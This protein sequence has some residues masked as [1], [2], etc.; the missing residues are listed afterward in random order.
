MLGLGPIGEGYSLIASKDHR[1]S[2]LDLPRT[3]IEPAEEFTT[4]VR[5]RLAQHYGE[6]VIAEHGRIPPCVNGAL[7]HEPHCLHAHRL[8]FPGLATLDLEDAGHGSLRVKHYDSFRE[9]R[10]KFADPGQYLYVERADGTC[11]VASVFGFVPRQFLRSAAAQALG[12]PQLA[13]WRSYPNPNV[14]RAAQLLL[15]P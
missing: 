8:V 2:M 7:Q 11:Q 9:A 3:M 6:A 5:A 14:I 13:D 12:T 4:A 1:P 10:E 15:C